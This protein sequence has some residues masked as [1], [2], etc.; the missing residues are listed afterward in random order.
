[1]AMKDTLKSTMTNY[2]EA[3][4]VAWDNVQTKVSLHCHTMHFQKNSSFIIFS[5][6]LLSSNV[7]ALKDPGIGKVRGGSKAEHCQLLAAPW[8]HPKQILGA[9]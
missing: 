3:D 5:F 6:R 9:F 7:A 2:T 8:S 4:K 1:M